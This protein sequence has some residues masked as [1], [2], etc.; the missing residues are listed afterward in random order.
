M[1]RVKGG[2]MTKKTR[3]KLFKQTKGFYSFGKNVYKRAKE[4]LQRAMRYSYRDRR[5]KK[6]DIRALWQVKINAAS[7][8]NGTTYSKLIHAL[9]KENIQLDRKILAYL[10]ENKPEIFSQIIAETNIKKTAS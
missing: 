2:V 10:A 7:R 5:T 1:V 9:K 6:R 4:R 3:R 8:I